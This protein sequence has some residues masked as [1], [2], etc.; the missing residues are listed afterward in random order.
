MAVSGGMGGKRTALA[1]AGLVLV[2]FLVSLDQTVVGTA[3]PRVVAELDGFELYAWVTT[4]Y[5]LAETV[6]IPIVGKLGDLWGRKWITV[7]GVAVFLVGSALCGIAQDMTQLVVFR[8]VQGLGGG[9]LLSTVFTSV[10]DIFP[11]PAR[12]ARYQ[13]LFFGVFSIS[14]VIGPSLG[15]WITDAFDWRYVFFLNLPLGVLSLIALPFVLP[16]GERR[17]AASI[18]YLG[19][20]TSTVAVVALLLALSWAGEGYGWGSTRVLAGLVVAAVFV[21]LFLPIEARSPEPILPLSMFRDRSFA[22]ASI[23]MFGVGI[24]MFGVILYTP[25]FVQGVLGYTATGSGA[26]LTPLILTMTAMGIVGGVLMARVNRIKPFLIAGTV[27]MALGAYL[28]STLGVGSTTTTVAL[29]L[30]VT[31][32]GL[33]LIMPT[34]T[35]AVQTIAGEENMG[36][37][38]AATQFIRSIGSTVGTAAIGTLVTSGYANGLRQ[39]VP[40]GTPDRLVGALE[41]PNAL[42]SPAALGALERVAGALPGGDGLVDG[43]LTAAREALAGAIQTGFLFVLATAMFSVA[44][45]LLMRNLRLKGGP[46]AG[47][48]PVR[49][50]ED[51]A[52]G[53]SAGASAASSASLP[54]EARR[55]NMED[56]GAAQEGEER[57]AVRRGRGIS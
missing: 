53:I 10:A 13:G 34:T 38:T 48:V 31:G 15:G 29:F 42:V 47:P 18:D 27:F 39:G 4:S 44:G 21:A 2:L 26:I 30:F 17:R 41:E 54:R 11:D 56:G 46:T 49:A 9:M 52:A 5:L 35:L 12:R 45:A 28:L 37:A 3:M 20:L 51:L 16:N 25:L 1:A 50:D 23:V 22:S 6:V 32:L 43:L 55:P 36:V 40:E 14:S 57:G 8:G 33:G 7:A 24:G 19:A